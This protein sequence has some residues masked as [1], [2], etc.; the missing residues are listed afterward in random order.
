MVET[1]DKKIL[2]VLPWQKQVSPITAFCVSQ[3]IDR[4]RTAAAL[5]FGD[6]F[7]AHSRNTCADIFLRSPCDYM[8]T[9]DDDMVVPFGDADWFRTYTGFNF[10]DYFMRLNA[11]DRLMSA[12]KTLVGSLYF[13]RYSHSNPVY[14]EGGANTAEAVYARSGPHDV[15]KPT[16]WVGTGCMLIH[17]SV[18]E[19]I[20]KRFP[21]LARGANKMG[22]Q[23]FTSTESYL[24]DGLDQARAALSSGAL[25]GESA[26]K[27]LS[28]LESTSAMA[29]ATNTLGFGE[30]VSFCIRAA[31]A[32]HQSYV[33]MGLICGHLGTCCY[34]PSNTGIKN[35]TTRSH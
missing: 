10:P 27:A 32:G 20:E 6:A 5:N 12:K 34:G 8:L 13:G 30:D 9:I 21:R 33:D 26:Y 35:A 1:F 23:W 31:S 24:M 25:T 4:R 15:V 2:V 3:I 7:V 16:K 19:D 14:N 22:G 18:F 11:L 17:R 28:I 29:A